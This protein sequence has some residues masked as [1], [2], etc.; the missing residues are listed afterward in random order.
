LSDASRAHCQH[1]VDQPLH[2]AGRCVVVGLDF[3]QAKGLAVVFAHRDVNL[4]D[5]LSQRK[6]VRNIG[7]GEVDARRADDR[8]MRHV[9][10]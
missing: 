5:L 8:S 1:A 3:H 6:L 4:I 9:G 2:L 7:G 10:Q